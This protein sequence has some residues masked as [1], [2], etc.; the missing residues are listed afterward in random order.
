VSA[1]DHSHNVNGS[2]SGV[3]AT[4]T[5]LVSGNTGNTGSGSAHNTMQ[6]SVPV[7]VLMKL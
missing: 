7:T 6:R 1:G 3:G 2:T 5:H 4:H